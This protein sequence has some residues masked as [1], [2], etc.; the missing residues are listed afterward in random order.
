VTEGV[1]RARY[2]LGGTQDWLVPGEVTEL[3]V[4]LA[5]TAHTVRAGHRLQLRWRA[6]ASRDS[7]ATSA[8]GC[9]R[10]SRAPTTWS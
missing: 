9:S 5:D 4:H 7:A 1:Q 8:P 2:R 3:V 6:A 10:S